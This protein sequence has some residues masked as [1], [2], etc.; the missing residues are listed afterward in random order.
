VEPD[1][2][3][4]AP[5]KIAALLGVLAEEYGDTPS[6]PRVWRAAIARQIPARRIGHYYYVDPEDVPKVAEHFGLRPRT[7]AAA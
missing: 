4:I 6:Y 1:V 2:S 3:Q 5:L 7:P